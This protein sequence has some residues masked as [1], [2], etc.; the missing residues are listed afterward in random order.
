M[1]FLRY[2]SRR[3]VQMLG[4]AAAIFWSREVCGIL[5]V[6]TAFCSTVFL[7]DL[8]GPLTA[9][10]TEN[11]TKAGAVSRP[12]AKTKVKGVRISGGIRLPLAVR[13]RPLGRR[14]LCPAIG[15]TP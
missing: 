2:R 15:V 10:R 13:G 1:R 5:L 3:A 14:V 7:P 12:Q 4:R 9:I 8:R 11:S 6:G